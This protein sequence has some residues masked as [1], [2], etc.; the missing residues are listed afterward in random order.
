MSG[1]SFLHSFMA[2]VDMRGANA[3]VGTMP[4]IKMTLLAEEQQAQWDA[5]DLVKVLEEANCKREELAN[6][7]RKELANKRRGELANKRHKELANKRC[8]E[9]ANKRH[10]ELANKRRKE[11]A[12][13][14]C[15]AQA[16]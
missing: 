1:P 12:N 11:L 9:L 7:R 10:E 2:P 6:K 8:E 5:D 15:D 13:K 14:R 16:A 4:D 3:A